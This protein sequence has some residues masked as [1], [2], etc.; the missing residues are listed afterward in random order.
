MQSSAMN[1]LPVRLSASTHSAALRRC[2]PDGTRPTGAR[3]L[4]AVDKAET[5]E[6]RLLAAFAAAPREQAHRRADPT[7][8]EE[9]D[10]E[11]AGS[12]DR[13]V[14]AQLRFQVRGLADLRAQVVDG[15]CE[16]LALGRDL[17]AQLLRLAFRH[18]PLPFSALLNS[19]ASWS[20]CSGTGG[21]PFLIRP[22]AKA[23]RTP[24]SDEQ[25]QGDG[26]QREPAG[27]EGVERGRNRCEEEA[28][29]VQG[30]DQG[31]EAEP[32]AEPEGGRLPLQLEGG[33]LLLEPEPRAGVPGYFS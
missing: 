24:A 12:G 5:A 7:G 15:L 27:H 32:D 4:V 1:C 28:D 14:G 18:A 8:H 9:P 25:E 10:T 21:V 2:G 16:L 17:V 6:A 31:T 23:P 30:D 11:R 20:A 3:W 26:E 19:L 29:R 22:I 33:E 13:E